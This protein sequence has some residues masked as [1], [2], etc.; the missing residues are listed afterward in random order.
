MRTIVRFFYRFHTFFL[1][2]LLQ[3]ICL[4]LLY[5][6]NPY[7]RS[8]ILNS[9]NAVTG[10]ILN[11]WSN[12][13]DYFSLSAANQQLSEENA[14]LTNQ[15]SDVSLTPVA[16]NVI[17][18]NDTLY[19]QQYEFVAAKVIGNTSHKGDNYLT[20]NIGSG[21]GVEPDMGVTG[22]NGIVGFV[23]TVSDNYCTVV[24]VLNT[25]FTASV[26]IKE[27][28]FFGQL[29]WDR[30]DQRTAI[31]EGIPKHA[32]VKVGD[33]V[34]TQSGTGRYPENLIAGIVTNVNSPQGQHNLDI[35]IE[36]A[37]D[38]SSVYHVYVVRNFARIELQQLNNQIA[39]DAE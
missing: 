2:L 31:L 27:S 10:S 26:R 17:K 39:N 23:K 29:R 30:E 25:D 32:N 1:F 24:S 21:V 11:V 38:F 22:P 33:V 8:G 13:T 20:L 36:L 19:R 28:N 4:G 34:V 7:Q 12:V 18:V 5:R 35:R 14:A 9:S 3:F 16:P 37:T 15:L 6:Y